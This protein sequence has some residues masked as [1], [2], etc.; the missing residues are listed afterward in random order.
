MVDH[1]KAE[2]AHDLVEMDDTF[3]IKAHACELISTADISE[4][5]L[6]K[7]EEVLYQ[8]CFNKFNACSHACEALLSSKSELIE[9][10]TDLKWSSSLDPRMTAEC[11]PD[12]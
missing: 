8:A 9:G 11:L 5:W 2:E 4:E 12:Y 3:C 1:G 7:E 6:N 10:T